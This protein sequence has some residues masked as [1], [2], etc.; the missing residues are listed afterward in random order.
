MKILEKPFGCCF[1]H[2]SF[3]LSQSLREHV[4]KTHSQNQSGNG[5]KST[6]L[7]KDEPVIKPAVDPVIGKSF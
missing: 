3:Q 5:L 1:C 2:M 7:K 4:E 6:A